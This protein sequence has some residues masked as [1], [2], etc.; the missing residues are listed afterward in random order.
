MS[1]AE[2]ILSPRAEGVSGIAVQGHLGSR[3][4][5]TDSRKQKVKHMSTAKSPHEKSFRPSP[6]E[7]LST[8]YLTSAPVKVI[9]NQEKSGKLSQPRETKRDRKRL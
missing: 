9:K 1:E 2:L 4:L 6:I 8:K 5:G 7:R 3:A